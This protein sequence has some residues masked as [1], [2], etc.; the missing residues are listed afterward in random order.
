MAEVLDIK[1]RIHH[2]VD[3]LEDGLQNCVQ[4]ILKEKRDSKL[5]GNFS[6]Q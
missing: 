6:G 1:G 5:D 2:E 3:V 4:L